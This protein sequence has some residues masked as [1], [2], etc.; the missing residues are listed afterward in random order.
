MERF[1]ES[2]SEDRPGDKWRGLFERHWEA[3]QRWFLSEGIKARPPYL[4]SRRALRTHMPEL[5]PIYDRLVELAGGGDLA[6]RFLSLYCPPPYLSGCSQAVWP[7]PD[8]LLVRNYDYHPHLLEAVIL[9]SAWQRPVLA[10]SDCL[11]GALDGINDAGLAVSL[12]FGGRRVVGDGF[13]VPLILRYIL[14]FCTTTREGVEVLSRV[15]SHMAYNVTLLDRSGRF[16]TVYIGPD[17]PTRV[18]TTLVATNHQEQVEWMQHARATATMER[19]RFLHFRLRESDSADRLIR[20]FLRSPIYSTDFGRG[21]GTLYTAVLRPN[22]DS[23]EYL[24]P[25]GH[26]PQ[27]LWRFEEGVKSIR[28]PYQPSTGLPLLH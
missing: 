23:V 11:W 17:R 20:A 3:Y 22:Q 26:W 6:A 21:N 15:P 13:G 10:T 25:N 18:L 9:R 5:L 27:S 8:S 24:W 2:L 12:T 7:G 1:F 16:N 14:E 4:T 19:E 28:Y